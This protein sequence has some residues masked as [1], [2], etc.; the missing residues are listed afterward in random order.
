MEE[1]FKNDGTIVFTA[2]MINDSYISKNTPNDNHNGS[3]YMMVGTEEG[4]NVLRGVMKF[5]LPKIPSGSQIVKAAIVLK[6]SDNLPARMKNVKPIEVH[7]I[8]SDWNETSVTWDSINNKYNEKIVTFF[9]PTLYDPLLPDD[10]ALTRID[11]TNLVKKWYSGS[12]NY[13]VMFKCVD[14][15]Y[16]EKDL[17]YMAYSSD[18]YNY[19][20]ELT[21]E[22][23]L[24]YAPKV[25][26]TY[27]ANKGLNSFMD[28]KT[29][30][31]G[32]CSSNANIFN[33]NI[34]HSVYLNKTINSKMPVSISLLRNTLDN[35]ELTNPFK[36]IAGWHFSYQE[37]IKANFDYDSKI[38]NVLDKLKSEGL[39]YYS[40]SGEVHYL[41]YKQ[42]D[43]GKNVFYDIEGLN[44]SVEVLNNNGT[45][46]NV[47]ILK[48]KDGNKYYF[49]GTYYEAALCKIEL[50]D[51]K[52]ITI[53]NEY[54]NV[55]NAANKYLLGE[56]SILSITDGD[57]ENI[58]INYQNNKVTV[59]SNRC[60][61]IITITD[62]KVTKVSNKY[63]N[64]ILE[65]DN[66]GIL[67]KIIDD[68]G[69]SLTYTYYDK[70]PYR[71]KEISEYGLNN[72]KGR[73]SKF[74]YEFNSTLLTDEANN[75]YRYIFNDLGN[76]IQTNILSK[77]NTLK[78]SYGFA[79]NYVDELNLNTTN[80]LL[81]STMPISY[82]LNKLRNSSY[83][84]NTETLFISNRVKEQGNT[85][86]Y[87][88]KL[89][90][91]SYD[92][93]NMTF[94]SNKT[95]TFSAYFKNNKSIRLSLNLISLD[96]SIEP[97]DEV[98]PPNTEYT[99]YSFTFTTEDI[100]TILGV[101][102]ELED[103]DVVYIDDLQLEEGD[104]VSRHNLIENSNFEDSLDGWIITSQDIDT[105]ASLSNPY[106]IVTLASNELALKINS[107]MS[108]EITLKQ[109]VNIKGKKGD[110]YTLGFWYKNE[111]RESANTGEVGNF[112][113]I[114]FDLVNENDEYGLGTYNISLEYYSDEWLY[115]TN[116][117]IADDDYNYLDINVLSICDVNNL[118]VTNF[119][120]IKNLGSY[121]YQYDEEGNLITTKDIAGRTNELK[122]DNNNQLV[123][124]FDSKGNNYKYEYDNN[125][126]TRILKGISPTCISNEI[127]YDSN[128]NPYKT[129]INNVNPNDTIENKYYYIRA[130]G[131]NKYIWLDTINRT[132]HLKENRCNNYLFYL[133]KNNDDYLIS[134]LDYYL[135]Y[136]N[137][138]LKLIKKN[139]SSLFNLIKKNNGSY[140]IKLKE[141]VPSE[142]NPEELIDKEPILYL[143]HDNDILTLSP[144]GEDIENY[145]FYFE[146]IDTN[147]FIENKAYYSS[148]GKR[149][150]KVV[151]ALGKETLYAISSTTGLTNSIT[152]AKGLVTEYT[153]NDRDELTS[154]KYD[155][156]TINYTL[157]KGFVT[158]I[159]TGNKNYKFE[160][161]EFYNP[162]SVSINNNTL[163]RSEY[164]SSNGKIK[165]T[166]YGNGAKVEYTYDNFNRIKDVKKYNPFFNEDEGK[167]VL[168]CDNTYN[169][170][171]DNLGLTSKIESLDEKYEYRYDF[172]ERLNEY[173]YNNTF[174]LNYL[175]DENNNI[176]EEKQS[177]N[178]INHKYIYTYNQ[179]DTVTNI[180][181]NN[182]NIR[183]DYDYLGR[184][185]EKYINNHLV[186][187]YSYKN[188]GKKTSLIID[189]YSIDNDNYQYIYDDLY[190]ITKVLLNDEVIHEYTYDNRN[191]LIE[192]IN[193]L[194]NRK[195]TYSYNDEGNILETKVF[196]LENNLLSTDTYEYSNTNWE[197]QLTK[198]NGESITYDAIGNPI[199]IGN[200]TL[201][202]ING[203]SLENYNNE[204][205]FKYNKDGIRT[206][207]TYNGIETNY[208]LDGTSIIFEDRN[209]N[210][211]Y[212]IRDNENNVIGFIYNGETYYYKKNI[213]Q[214][215]IGIYDNTFNQIVT[216]TY[217]S[218]GNIISIVDTSTNN[219]GTINPYR[220][221]SYYYDNETELYYLNTRYYNP[222]WKRF[223]NADGI[224]AA[225]DC[226]TNS[227]LYFYA[228][229][230]PISYSDSDGNFSF[231]SLLGE[232]VPAIVDVV[233]KVGA[234]AAASIVGGTI[235]TVA[236]V[237]VSFLAI[238]AVKTV[239]KSATKTKKKKKS[240]QCYSV[241]TLV[242]KDG[243]NAKE[244]TVEY[245]GITIDLERRKS[246]HERDKNR[247]YLYFDPLNNDTC[248]TRDEARIE[249]Q[250]C[251]ITHTTL[252]RT[253]NGINNAIFSIG[254]NSRLYPR[255]VT[256]YG[257]Y[258]RDTGVRKR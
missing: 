59:S 168:S 36:S 128:G 212:Y 112:A 245:C 10:E 8:T 176:K 22:E 34:F 106:E 162:T 135:N 183:Y 151:D 173:N 132:L 170:Y 224:I 172:A 204:V 39:T 215:V 127:K 28:Y 216:Y 233:T 178:D 64:N 96:S 122:Y 87:S 35:K 218:W 2:S 191:Q 100:Y 244:N 146:D 93:I 195:Y 89:T 163:S 156:K 71:I 88:A 26:I 111:G 198:F 75:R 166:S 120:L 209:G 194:L 181:I 174:R 175:Y 258:Y 99:R 155:N 206:K 18:Y 5:E 110:V 221:R 188:N 184:L 256:I 58:N 20:G 205:F 190:N 126:K 210:V 42:S 211:I 226:I 69:I 232:F 118:Y 199:S 219:I 223:I 90:A 137:N 182:D 159:E 12:N 192:D 116:S 76:T 171:Y 124:T 63:G 29:F 4:N 85:G 240:N 133:E 136:S 21:E 208:Y 81:S 70:Y 157:D 222:K 108:N 104:V 25:E 23:Y 119:S 60:D 246:E 16:N 101:D 143:K 14:E 214:D 193:H 142:D 3:K 220:Y 141:L 45:I 53:N 254:I 189:K 46:S 230:N 107:G 57:N 139:K 225:N 203:R 98:I 228:N 200:K 78:H 140:L 13:G 1:E 11:V 55:P 19:N 255:Y 160:H 97:I 67:S 65:Y 248:L 56:A 202:W 44:I 129:I 161:D 217:D 201:K 7:E 102:L 123:A 237:A 41:L 251:I 249:E 148:D 153:Y 114:Q 74:V 125:I 179:D 47:Y 134:I 27:K 164:E 196:D 66:E 52:V 227:N 83:E 91:S 103:G 49:E 24:E 117:F 92:E 32:D 109:R 243:I 154:V 86:E 115:F 213:Q 33:G 145:E 131:T 250:H 236:V 61:T 79:N 231:S 121:T 234:K 187:K 177:L 82:T 152:N 95:Y 54:S 9:Y 50:T 207:K 257:S 138:N 94:E 105:G 84:T 252:D 253:K 197:D 80:K 235:T 180:N 51:G 68:A 147:E 73:F 149:I 144:L 229:N 158:N 40:E 6:T 169:Y 17:V 185:K 113:N 242:D 130:K 30:N 239:T 238:E 15:S 186:G 37:F 31:I 247:G 167:E 43:D 48:D 72:T 241:Y 150:E 165:S 38:T 62:N 77:D